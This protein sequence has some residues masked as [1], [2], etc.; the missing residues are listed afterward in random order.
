M[1]TITK[2]VEVEL[3][4]EE[5]YDLLEKDEKVEFFQWFIEDFPKDAKEILL[6]YGYEV[7]KK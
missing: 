6:E 3:E 4:K 5:V 1:K 2:E 7:V